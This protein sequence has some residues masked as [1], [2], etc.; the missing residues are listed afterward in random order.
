M[1]LAF[2]CDLAEIDECVR[3]D[4][5]FLQRINLDTVGQVKQSNRL[6]LVDTKADWTESAP[7]YCCNLANRL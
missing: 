3:E 2:R 4:K 5:L 6:T 1:R 7:L